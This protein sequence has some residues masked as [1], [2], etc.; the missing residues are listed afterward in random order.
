MSHTWTIAIVVLAGALAYLA[1]KV[2][3]K[4]LL[5]AGA[6]VIVILAAIGGWLRR[7]GL[8]DVWEEFTLAVEA[9]WEWTLIIVGGILMTVFAIGFTGLSA[10]CGWVMIHAVTGS[11]GWAWVAAIA[12]GWIGL[13]VFIMKVCI[14][15]QEA[16]GRANLAT[17]GGSQ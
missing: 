1:T 2:T 14:G 16:D 7:G 11:T 15:V 6:W 17:W 4:G 8:I 5:D 12:V 3:R 10:F 13:C 9:V